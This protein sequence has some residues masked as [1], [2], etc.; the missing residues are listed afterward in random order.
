MESAQR[1]EF[2]RPMSLR[3]WRISDCAARLIPENCLH[4]QL[5]RNP[6]PV[7]SWCCEMNARAALSRATHRPRV[8]GKKSK[9][10]PRIPGTRK[11]PRLSG[12]DFASKQ[13]VEAL[14]PSNAAE[15][16]CILDELNIH[17]EIRNLVGFYIADRRNK[18]PPAEFRKQIR[19]LRKS[20]ENFSKRLSAAN[21]AVI[22]A[23]NQELSRAGYEQIQ[24]GETLLLSF[25][26]L[27]EA[28]A[29]IDKAESGAGIRA[30]R[31]GHL[32]L[33]GL[34]RFYEDSTGKKPSKK[35]E[36]R[37]GRFVQAVNDQIPERFKLTG[38]EHLL[39]MVG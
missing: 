14:S 31:E 23:L 26:L 1:L 11:I 9:L 22:E 20:L 17:N 6:F 2:E 18:M 15:Q 10:P 35:M 36:S 27:H 7:R 32:L 5:P 38:L 37:F 8:R 34:A 12:I 39:R 33:E 29:S 24:D 19:E 25:K 16:E 30:N 13:I 4:R 28:L 3:F 21:S